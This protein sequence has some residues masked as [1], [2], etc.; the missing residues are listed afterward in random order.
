MATPQL[1][2]SDF[3]H[4]CRNNDIDSVKSLVE[5][6]TSD[7]INKLEPNGSTALHAAS[8]NGHYEIVELLLKKGASKSI[9]NQY[10]CTPYEEAKSDAIKQLFSGENVN[11]RF[12]GD[13]NNTIE[14]IRV[15]E[16]IDHEAKAIRNMLK[17]YSG[18]NKKKKKKILIEMIDLGNYKD[19]DKIKWYFDQANDNNDPT[20]ILT[21]Y[22]E[23]TEFYQ[24]LNR[25]LA[26]AHQLNPTD[27]N[28]RQ[29]LDFLN[30]ICCHPSFH[31]YEFQ[32][33]TY[34]G[35]KMDDNDFKQ[36]EIGLK[37]MTK[38]LLSTSKVRDIA[39]KFA[40]KKEAHADGNT[41]K[42]ACIC[43]YQIR[44]AHTALDIQELSI[45]RHEQEVLVKPYSAFQVVNIREITSYYGI[46]TEI[47]LR[48]CKSFIE[49]HTAIAV[50]GGLLAV[51]MGAIGGLFIDD[52]ES[53][54]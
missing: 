10:N 36:Y 2:I 46:L 5:T 24:R 27:E 1:S 8:Y 12:V 53:Q 47:E 19:I 4:A 52:E 25:A 14:W 3:Y 34:R 6:M 26:R 35:M 49:T 29:L 17:A 22:T 37:F 54:N 11:D 28:Q 23:Q 31:K 7:Q 39:E 43:K 41:I 50:G 16:R 15:G 20:Y 44:K 48:Q 9:K 38:S 13:S 18:Q 32:G 42:R 21:A 33:E 45:F 30:L 51:A 40:T